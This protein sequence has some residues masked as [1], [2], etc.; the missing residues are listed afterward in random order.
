MFLLGNLFCVGVIFKTLGNPKY[1]TAEMK[2][3]YNAEIALLHCCDLF[4]AGIALGLFF[5][6]HACYLQRYLFCACVERFFFLFFFF[7]REHILGCQ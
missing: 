4:F 3:V 7:Y 1:S 5:S 6:P 2:C